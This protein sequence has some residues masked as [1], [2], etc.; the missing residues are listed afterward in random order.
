MAAVFGALVFSGAAGCLLAKGA[1]DRLRRRE[2]AR[3]LRGG[4]QPW[5]WALQALGAGLPEFVL[6]YAVRASTRAASRAAAHTST[7]AAAGACSRGGAL[8]GGAVLAHDWEGPSCSG[9]RGH[10]RLDKALLAG[11]GGSL[12]KEGLRR[13]RMEFALAGCLLG[14]MVGAGLSGLLVVL[15]A[16]LGLGVG[17]RMPSWAL[18]QRI[19]QR[20]GE[21]ERHLPEMLDV[22]ALG[23]RSGLSFDRALGAYCGHFDTLLA[24]ELD[25]AREKWTC[26]LMTRD[27]SLVELAAAV[28]SPV[29]GRVL[30]DVARSLRHGS[31]LSGSLEAVAVEARKDYRARRQE[32]VAKAPVKMM[33]P[34]GVLI[35]PAMLILVLGPVM[36]ELMAGF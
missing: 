28:D 23:L 32:E 3:I 6:Q 36:L 25:I 31:A 17:W 11:L 18:N 13:T 27:E 20:A 15:L 16:T 8:P 24:K 33:L 21:V 5:D 12:T 2:A 10:D 29:F 35:L 34:T 4:E 14:G 9:R 1:F 30:G 19:R 22:V 7:R 26:G